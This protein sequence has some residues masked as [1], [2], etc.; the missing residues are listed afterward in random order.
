MRGW[1]RP[2]RREDLPAYLALR[3]EL[4][5][6]AGE[7]GVETLLEG[8]R[9]AA[10][11]AEVEGELV[12]FVEVG[13]RPYAEGCE[14]SPVGYLEGWYVRPPWRRQG[15]GRALVER[16]EAWARAQ[17]CTEMASDAQ[18]ENLPG[19]EAHRHLGYQE[20]ERIVCFRKPL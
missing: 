5:P 15:V 16:A 18:L 8:L 3:R 7:E 6:E 1:V 17:G 12:G 2:L 10:F 4:W 11:V 14:T 19:Q 9:Q 20:V 13:L